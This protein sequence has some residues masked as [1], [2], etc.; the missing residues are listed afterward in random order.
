MPSYARPLERSGQLANRY[1]IVGAYGG[2]W[3][4][5]AGSNEELGC[6]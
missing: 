1:H 3:V 4:C 2:A 5:D 6:G